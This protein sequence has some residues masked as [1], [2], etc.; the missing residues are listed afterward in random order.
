MSLYL[1]VVVAGAVIIVSRL[2]VLE[3]LTHTSPWL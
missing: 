3:R 2:L 1:S